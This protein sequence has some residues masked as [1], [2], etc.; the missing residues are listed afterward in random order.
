MRS[1]SWGSLTSLH[2]STHFSRDDLH[3]LP[4]AP[5]TGSHLWSEASPDTVPRE[6]APQEDGEVKGQRWEPHVVALITWYPEERYICKYSSDKSPHNLSTLNSMHSFLLKIDF[7]YSKFWL[8]FLSQLF[9]GPFLPL[10]PTSFLFL[11]SGYKQASIIVIQDK[12]NQTRTDK[13]NRVGKAKE[14]A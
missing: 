11:S 10:K 3:S 6:A 5:A 4:G 8:L 12:Q 9:S 2:T 1:D 14:K 7:A 13:P